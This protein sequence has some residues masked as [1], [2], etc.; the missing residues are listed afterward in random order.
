M[1]IGKK[2]TRYLH[3]RGKL[4]DPYDKIQPIKLP[5]FRS[6]FTVLV[7]ISAASLLPV[8]GKWYYLDNL[9]PAAGAQPVLVLGMPING[10]GGTIMSHELLHERVLIAHVPQLQDN[11]KKQFSMFSQNLKAINIRHISFQVWFNWGLKI[12]QPNIYTFQS[13]CSHRKA[14]LLNA[15]AAPSRAVNVIKLVCKRGRCLG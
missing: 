7:P 9:V 2:T 10:K 12:N 8:L 15:F 13:R 11:S 1:G 4:T 5:L 3:S 14:R 6:K